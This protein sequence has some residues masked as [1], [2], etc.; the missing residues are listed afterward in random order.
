MPSANGGSAAYYSSIFSLPFITSPSK[1]YRPSLKT[2][3]IRTITVCH[4][5]LYIPKLSAKF[6][7]FLMPF[8]QE[9]NFQNIHTSSDKFIKPASTKSKNKAKVHS[10]RTVQPFERK[11]IEFIIE[12][13]SIADVFPPFVRLVIL[14]G[15]VSFLQQMCLIAVHRRVLRDPAIKAECAKMVNVGSTKNI[16]SFPAYPAAPQKK[17]Q[18]WSGNACRFSRPFFSLSYALALDNQNMRTRCS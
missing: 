1:G 9:I 12:K 13:C 7:A 8:C 3:L 4:M 14:F 17:V 15:H 6:I 11:H 2:F 16:S 10:S 5:S 18:Y